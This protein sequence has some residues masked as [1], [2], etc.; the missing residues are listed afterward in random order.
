RFRIGY[1]AKGWLMEGTSV[2]K[3]GLLVLVAA[4]LATLGYFYLSHQQLNSYTV[5]VRFKDTKGL[6][7]QSIVR[8]KG[9]SIGEVKGVRLDQSDGT[10]LPT[11]EL[12]IDKQYSIPS[13]YHFV[14]A[15]GLLITNP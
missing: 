3:V 2:A 5:R 12:A 13:N 10:T 8:I 1:E 6:L 14:I 4:V 11:V 7:K 15:S 9:V